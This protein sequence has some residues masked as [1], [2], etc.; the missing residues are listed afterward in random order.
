MRMFTIAQML[1]IATPLLTTI[2]DKTLFNEPSKEESAQIVMRPV[3]LQSYKVDVHASKIKWLAK[4]V[5]GEHNGGIAISYGEFHVQNNMVTD[6]GLNID[7]RSITDADLTDKDSNNKLV[8]TLKSETFFNSTKYPDAAFASTSVVHVSGTQYTV[9]GNL[10]IKGITNE[11]S[12]PASITINKNKLS[13]TAKI[14]VDRTKFDIKIRSKSF[15][16]NL[17]DKVI[18]DDFILDIAL[19]ANAE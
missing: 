13:A 16:G 14:T 12:F 1:I 5:T 2:E 6:A 19:F 17:G 11:V 10:T 4:K 3:K 15:L 9:T 7:T 18:Y 8:T